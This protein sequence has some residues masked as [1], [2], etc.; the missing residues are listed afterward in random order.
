M[1]SLQGKRDCLNDGYN[2]HQWLVIFMGLEDH[3]EVIMAIVSEQD[4]TGVR[5]CILV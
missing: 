5:N 1:T 4:R 3:A 2:F